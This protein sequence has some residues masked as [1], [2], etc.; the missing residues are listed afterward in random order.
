MR[1]SGLVFRVRVVFECC[2]VEVVWCCAA[3]VWAFL[4][5]YCTG[6]QQPATMIAWTQS[7]CLCCCAMLLV[8]WYTVVAG[9]LEWRA[10]QL[11]GEFTA[12]CCLDTLPQLHIPTKRSLLGKAREK[13]QLLRIVVG[14]VEFVLE[15]ARGSRSFH[16]LGPSVPRAVLGA[17]A[18]RPGA[19]ILG[20]GRKGRRRRRRRRRCCCCCGVH[21]RLVGHCRP[22]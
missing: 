5:V 16:S 1:C 11:P 7:A 15:N 6:R 3:F 10:T 12:L 22:G 9:V 4:S 14:S 18:G 17:Q 13:L 19:T 20:C 2:C 21:Q 8:C